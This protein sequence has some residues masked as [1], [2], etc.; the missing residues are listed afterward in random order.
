MSGVPET[1]RTDLDMTAEDLDLREGA[2]WHALPIWSKQIETARGQTEEAIVALSERFAGIVTRLDGAMDT[3]QREMGARNVMEDARDGERDLMLV[4][5]ALKAM[6][7]TRDMLAD[8]VRSLSLYMDELGRMAADVESIAFQTNMLA[9]NAAIEAAHAGTAG[10]GF[11]VVAQEVRALSNAARGTG[12]R[13]STKIA[14]ISKAL[15]NIGETNEKVSQ[16]DQQA[17]EQSK[18]HIR[19][20]LSRFQQSVQRL[21]ETARRSNEDGAAIRQE[22][23]ESLVQL[24]FQDRVSQ[25]LHQVCDSMDAVAQLRADPTSGSDL[26]ELA[27]EH[28]N[29]MMGSYT[30][31]EQRLNHQGT[32]VAKVEPQAVTYF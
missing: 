24:Q 6:Q 30:T 14:D 31:T 32:T 18:D 20:V 28:V 13:I 5:D 2:C 27:R 19:A 7:Q 21:T 9:L 12:Q 17:V 1:T 23:S 25:I 15:R 29:E 26:E 3:R 16:R 8:E 4:V 22:V 11:A 10:K